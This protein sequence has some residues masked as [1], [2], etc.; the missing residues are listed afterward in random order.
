MEDP[1]LWM[2]RW[3]TSTASCMFLFRALQ[4]SSRSFSKCLQKNSDSSRGRTEPTVT[5]CSKPW[6]AFWVLQLIHTRTECMRALIIQTAAGDNCRSELGVL[7]RWRGSPRQWPV[8]VLSTLK[9]KGETSS[10]VCYKPSHLHMYKHPCMY[11]HYG[12]VG[13]IRTQ[14]RHPYIRNKCTDSLMYIYI[15]TTWVEFSEVYQ[16]QV[17][18]RL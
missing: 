16:I 9:R 2:T 3:R 4:S 15:C 8:W 7:L 13:S 14:R 6:V 5:N 11:T 12:C 18:V 1:I 10:D 17:H